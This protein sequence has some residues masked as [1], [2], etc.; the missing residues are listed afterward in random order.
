M[1]LRPLYDTN[2]VGIKKGWCYFTRHSQLGEDPL[3]R[4]VDQ[5]YVLGLVRLLPS[6]SDSAAESLPLRHI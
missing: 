4:A 6:A 3:S 2:V 5:G 1:D